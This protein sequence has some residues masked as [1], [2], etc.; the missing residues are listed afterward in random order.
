MAWVC[1]ERSDPQLH[2]PHFVSSEQTSREEYDIRHEVA[3]H[4]FH[5][6]IRE[7]VSVLLTHETEVMMD[8]I[9]NAPIRAVRQLFRYET[10][11]GGIAAWSYQCLEFRG[12]ASTLLFDGWPEKGWTSWTSADDA[13]SN[14]W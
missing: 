5:L 3:V 10:E 2:Q 14:L 4:G 1:R 13:S 12:I 9:F 7:R 8:L 11:Q 6:A